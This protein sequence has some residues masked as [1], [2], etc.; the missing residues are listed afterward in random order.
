MGAAG[1]HSRYP[2]LSPLLPLLTQGQG[3]AYAFTAHSALH[4][5]AARGHVPV[6]RWL[7]TQGTPVEV[8]NAGGATALHA[9][10]SNQQ[11]Q[12]VAVLLAE[13]GADLKV[14]VHGSQRLH[15]EGVSVCF[16]DLHT[17]VHHQAFTGCEVAFAAYM[18]AR[19][20]M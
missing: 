10:A 12:A 6:L 2:L 7:L 20:V 4:W 14:S 5:A 9:A 11:L 8:R 15:T 3:T 17:R 18:C 16:L 13:A 19:H 1:L